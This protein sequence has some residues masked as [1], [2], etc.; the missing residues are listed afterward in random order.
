[1]L[2]TTVVESELHAGLFKLLAANVSQER[3][4]CGGA[5][6]GHVWRCPCVRL[7]TP[8]ND[9]EATRGGRAVILHA[10][11]QCSL[12]LAPKSVISVHQLQVRRA[13]HKFDR[14]RSSLFLTRSLISD[15]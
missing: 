14:N 15:A 6:D 5:P 4:S 12:F 9:L 13:R 7:H 3:P 10:A 11:R 2:P 8:A 1:M